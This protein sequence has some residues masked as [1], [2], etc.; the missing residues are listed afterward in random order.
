MRI[1]EKSPYND[2]LLPC[3]LS[4]YRQQQQQQHYPPSRRTQWSLVEWFCRG[5]FDVI[6]LSLSTERRNPSL[7]FYMCSLCIVWG[8]D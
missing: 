6:V 8:E 5:C 1:Y 4:Y 7:L 2:N 3:I